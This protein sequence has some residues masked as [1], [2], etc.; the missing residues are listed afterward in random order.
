MR[1]L[2]RAA[3]GYGG[4]AVVIAAPDPETQ[5]LLEKAL[6][7]VPSSERATT[8]RL[9]ARLAIELYYA[10]PDRARE[11]SQAAVADA[12]ASGD[13]GALAAALNA[14]RVAL[15]DPAHVD[16]RL[17]VVDE[18]VQAA[19][20]AGER[21]AALQARN[22]RV[23]DLWE[24]GRIREAAAEIDAYEALAE[25]VGLPHYRWY[26][27][28]WRAGL[29]LLAGRWEEATA[30]GE[31]A[32]TLGAQADDPNAPL[33]IR[34]Q[35]EYALH[36]QRRFGEIDRDWIAR[37]A[38]DSP[39]PA[40]WLAW[41]AMIDA[42]TGRHASARA[43]LARLTRDDCAALPM[44][45]NWLAACE[46]ADA[47]ATVGDRFAAAALHARLA[48]HAHLTAVIARGV[49]CE[50]ITE[51]HLGRLAATLG[52]LDE[53]E[54]RLRRAAVANDRAG[55]RP[56]T[57]TTLT[58]LGEVLAA[59]GK[60]D[61]ARETLTEAITLAET[62]QMPAVTGEARAALRQLAAG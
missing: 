46:L 54:T 25:Q 48:P 56:Y 17:S 55:A 31:R 62:L 13:G 38:A 43:T 36:V 23:V 49:G 21:E 34:V 33:L 6:A 10:D 8:A 51:H 47:A 57:A 12:R 37:A 41:L 39:E 16:E 50:N 44:R 52:G 11:L 59:R 5:A 53:A 19:D 27:P 2:G 22:W 1:L 40:P 15:W 42:N 29:A 24:L 28:L 7:G 18:M 45:T 20:A 61:A 3:L 32:L 26:V 58:R 14:R 30:L 9:R 35:R 60:H 4:L